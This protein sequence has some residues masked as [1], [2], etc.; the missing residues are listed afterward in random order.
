MLRTRY[1][2]TGPAASLKGKTFTFF[3]LE[4]NGLDR[5]TAILEIAGL[6]ISATDLKKGDMR[7]EEFEALIRFYGVMNPA[8]QAVHKIDSCLLR[9]KGKDLSFVLK[10]FSLFSQ[11]TLLSGHNIY[12]FDLPILNHHCTQAG[13]LIESLGAI[14]TCVVARETLELPNYRLSTLAEYFQI[15]GRPTHRAL[16]DVRA[17]AE[18]FRHLMADHL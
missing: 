8:A 16:D 15:K 5:T 10:D 9:E 11:G 3:D 13:I 2:K 12:K 1:I 18:V 6:R 4:T 14:D 17:T 7:G